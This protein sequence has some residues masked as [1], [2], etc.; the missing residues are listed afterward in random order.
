MRRIATAALA[1]GLLAAVAA[2]GASPRLITHGPRTKRWIALTFDADMTYQMIRELRSGK[3]KSWYDRKLVRTLRRTHTPATIFLTGL[4]TRTYR[5]AVRSFARDSLFELDNH[6]WDH[7]AWAGSC[8]G[9]PAVRGRKAKRAEVVRT[10]K[11]IKKVAGVRPR[12]FRFPG[13]CHT[14]AD[15]RLV[16]SLGEQ[17]VQWDVIS[18]DSF[19]RD[20]AKVEHEV[21]RQVRPGSIVVM[22]L[23]GPARTPATAPAV[24]A[25]I[26]KLR[27]DGYR[28]VKLNRLLNG[29]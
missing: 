13:G 20:P 18:G 3:V 21:L 14:R 28:F 29:A 23:I 6:S 16:A 5:S 12:Y 9:L 19:L 27:A 10:A 8:Y 4:W 24:K 11:I 26:P 7:R 22:H 25:L 15:V 2:A 1:L 17:P